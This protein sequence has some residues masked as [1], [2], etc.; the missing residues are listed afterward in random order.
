MPD[1]CTPARGEGVASSRNDCSVG[2][3]VFTW[4]LETYQQRRGLG[5]NHI[6]TW[7]AALAAAVLIAMATNALGW[8]TAQYGDPLAGRSLCE[9]AIMLQDD[10]PEGRAATL[11]SLGEIAHRLEEHP[12]AA[13]YY[14]QALQ[15]RQELHNSY[16][17]ANTHAALGAVHL[18]MGEPDRARAA[19]TA[20]VEL[21]TAQRRLDEADAI[22]ARLGSAGGKI[23]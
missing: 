4:S 3:T 23:D 9:S 18:A 16:E 20:A 6:A 10:D 12:D 22:R 11:D 1:P 7:E 17:E 5:R 13:A 8:W 15:L 21:Y 19:L 14:E 2:A